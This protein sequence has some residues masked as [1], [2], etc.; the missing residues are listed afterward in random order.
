MK[1]NKL[2]AYALILFVLLIPVNIGLLS[3]DEYQGPVSLIMM[4]L[5]EFLV[6]AAFVIGVDKK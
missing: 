6:L 4:I 3:I 1:K 2:I 5:I